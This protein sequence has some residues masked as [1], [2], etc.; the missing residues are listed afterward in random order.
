MLAI[1]LY[2]SQQSAAAPPRAEGGPMSIPVTP[3]WKGYHTLATVIIAIAVALVGWV[4]PHE[5]VRVSW[6]LI[7]VLLLSFLVIAGDGITG[8]LGGLLIDERNKMSL[9]R[10]QLVL[11]TVL[12]L[13]AFLA[14]AVSRVREG[15]VADPLAIAVPDDLWILLGISTASL[16]GSPLIKSI[17]RRQ[18]P[19]D[20]QLAQTMSQLREQGTDPA[21]L[22]SEGLLV[23]NRD[24]AAARWADMFRGDESGNA[25]VLD[26]AKVQMFFFTIVVVIAYAAALAAALASGPVGEFPD[27]SQGIVALLAISHAGYLSA[28]GVTHSESTGGRP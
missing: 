18:H 24:P 20:R 23:V 8:R 26:L 19:D 2:Q 14:I 27:V 6:L 12:I 21:A 11:W 15:M 16:V 17:K 9:S 10:F 25:A 22:N 4:V 5:A 3:R 1:G 28:K 13:S 7:V